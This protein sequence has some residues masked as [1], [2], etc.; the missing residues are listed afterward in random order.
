M[1]I[2]ARLGR[3]AM[4][5]RDRDGSMAVELAF[6]I[7]V[8]LGL[9]LSGVEITRFV[10]LNQKIE[11]TTATVADLVSQA[12]ALTGADVDALFSAGLFVMDPFDL[13][14]DGDIVVSS[15]VGEDGTARVD[16]QRN[17]GQGAAG[18]RFGTVGGGAVLPAGFS[19]GDGESVVVAEVFY[20]Y[21]PMFTG[22][23]LVDGLVG[24]KELYGAAL[25]RPRFTSR[26]TFTP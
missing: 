9:I 17:L 8:V 5:W 6:A 4:P 11:R 23:S 14:Q 24:E 26:I 2:G 1:R 15:I 20:D 18:S 3:L 13:T 22:G 7:P 25:F 21:S 12:E 19:V 16:W 10:L